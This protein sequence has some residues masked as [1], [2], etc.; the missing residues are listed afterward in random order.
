MMIEVTGGNLDD[1][2]NLIEKPVFA[3]GLTEDKTVREKGSKRNRLY[4]RQC[5]S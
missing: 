4:V 3:A 5:N 2:G 1:A